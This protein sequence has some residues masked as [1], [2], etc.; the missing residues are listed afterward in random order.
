VV[1]TVTT[2]TCVFLQAADRRWRK[3][4]DVEQIAEVVVTK[5][6]IERDTRGEYTAPELSAPEP[7]IR[8]FVIGG[9]SH[10]SR[11]KSRHIA[12]GGAGHEMIDAQYG[13]QL[14]C[15]RYRCDKGCRRRLKT[16]AVHLA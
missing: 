11:D 13:H 3:R 16:G 9:R 5:F 15:A 6:V 7:D 1:M 10:V 14:I 12:G 8:Q 4:S 2:P